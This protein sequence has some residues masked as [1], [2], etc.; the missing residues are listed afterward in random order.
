MVLRSYFKIGGQRPLIP[1]KAAPL[2]PGW[3]AGRKEEV[4]ERQEASPS[5]LES[6]QG[7]QGADTCTKPRKGEARGDLRQHSLQ[8]S[9]KSFICLFILKLFNVL[10]SGTFDC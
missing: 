5:P 6:S 9:Y 7:T 8:I 4:I 2:P 1:R 10:K 3:E